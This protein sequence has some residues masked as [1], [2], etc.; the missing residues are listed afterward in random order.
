MRIVSEMAQQ[1]VDTAVNIYFYFFN[2]VGE[3]CYFMV[4]SWRLRF[5]A[6]KL[7]FWLITNSLA[8]LTRVFFSQTSTRVQE[9]LTSTHNHEVTPYPPEN[10]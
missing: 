4:N 6:L 3:M 9:I 1:E 2:F 8:T 7:R 5:G 10:N